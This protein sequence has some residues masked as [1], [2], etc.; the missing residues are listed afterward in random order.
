MRELQLFPR[1]AQ[2]PAPKILLLVIA[3]GLLLF[4]SCS[5]ALAK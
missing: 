1:A 5:G 3:L 2:S 4:D